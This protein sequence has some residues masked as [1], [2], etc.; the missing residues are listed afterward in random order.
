MSKHSEVT[1][2]MIVAAKRS[3]I[4]TKS[5]LIPDEDLPWSVPWSVDDV[6]VKIYRSMEKAH[7]CGISGRNRYEPADRRSGLHHLG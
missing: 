6:I 4:R 5:E 7:Q 2:Q 3:L 1:P